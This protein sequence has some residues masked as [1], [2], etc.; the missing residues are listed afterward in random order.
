MKGRVTPSSLHGEQ[1][2]APIY[3]S[4]ESEL[5]RERLNPPERYP[6]P[7][8]DLVE[9]TDLVYHNSGL[10]TEGKKEFLEITRNS[11]EILSSMLN[12]AELNLIKKVNRSLVLHYSM[13]VIYHESDVCCYCL[14]NNYCHNMMGA[15]TKIF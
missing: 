5:D 15:H 6:I 4:L 1:N 14:A 10:S 12:E 13:G 9:D 2:S 3:S 7:T 11:V 8:M